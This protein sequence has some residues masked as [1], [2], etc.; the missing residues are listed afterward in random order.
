LGIEIEQQGLG[1]SAVL[2]DN[3]GMVV[4]ANA[5]KVFAS[6]VSSASIAQS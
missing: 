4:T 1:V 3:D 6:P 5:L 2:V